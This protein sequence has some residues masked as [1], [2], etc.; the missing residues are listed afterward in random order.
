MPIHPDY[1]QVSGNKNRY[2]NVHTGEQVTRYRAR[3]LGAQRMGYRSQSELSR[4]HRAHPRYAEFDGKYYDSFKQSNRGERAIANA[5]ALA[6]REGR[7]FN[8]ARFKAEVI[9]ARNARPR[10]GQPGGPAYT[11]FIERYDMDPGE[12]WRDS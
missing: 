2:Y 8:E 12:S 6:R 4:E 7:P 1:R 5:K 3:S 11:D 9:A 10:R